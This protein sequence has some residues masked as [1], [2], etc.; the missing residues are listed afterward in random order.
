[1]IE[2]LSQSGAPLSALAPLRAE[3]GYGQTQEAFLAEAAPAS[4]LDVVLFEPPVYPNR[5]RGRGTEGWVD[6]E[7]VVDSQGR[8]YDI[9]VTAAEPAG[10]FDSAALTAAATYVFVPFELDGSIYERRVSLRM[11]FALE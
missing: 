6:L 9:A 5:A 11:R 7:F 2:A 1:M 10:E 8:P 3:L 4:E